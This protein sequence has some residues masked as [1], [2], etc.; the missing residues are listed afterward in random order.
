ML[1]RWRR[2]DRRRPSPTAVTRS[3][4]AQFERFAKTA[5]VPEDMLASVSSI[6]D[7]S[8]LLDTIA[9]Q[10]PLKLEARQK[11]LASADLEQTTPSCCSAAWRPRSTPGG[12]I[13]ASADG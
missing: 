5:Q 3:V 2:R 6:D 7:P 10:V 8:R 1:N 13:G 12:W 9:A 4:F 11:I